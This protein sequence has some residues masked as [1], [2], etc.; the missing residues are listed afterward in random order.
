[1]NYYKTLTLFIIIS[2]FCFLLIPINFITFEKVFIKVSLK[3][4]SNLYDLRIKTFP[5]AENIGTKNKFRINLEYLE[6]LEKILDL[7]LKNLKE[8]LTE[9]KGKYWVIP[10]KNITIS[11]IG[12]KLNK[13]IFKSYV[14]IFN[15][16]AILVLFGMLLLLFFYFK[17][18]YYLQ[19][20]L[21]NTPILSSILIF[22]IAV[23][24]VS[25]FI[26]HH[27][28]LTK[29]FNEKITN[30]VP[31]YEFA[32]YLFLR[33]IILFVE[34]VFL[35]LIAILL[36]IKKLKCDALAFLWL[37]PII[38]ILI[39]IYSLAYNIEIS[40]RAYK[41]IQ[42]KEWENKIKFTLSCYLAAIRQQIHKNPI[43][44]IFIE[45]IKIPVSYQNAT[46]KI[47][48]FGNL[49]ELKAISNE[50]RDF[51]HFIFQIKYDFV[52][53]KILSEKEIYD[54]YPEKNLK[55]SF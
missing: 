15:L 47:N 19:N 27:T 7:D 14:K 32:Q 3:K 48:I 20:D 21:E 50:K 29:I 18:K 55:N 44:K 49:Y 31:I 33:K 17:Q 2:I 34:I 30:Q 52:K 1:M 9:K 10:I 13:E 46:Y 54:F 16:D 5:N 45:N 22:V 26:L 8:K 41:S 42:N 39:N 38:F 43:K 11:A 40:R 24:L 37:V 23:G 6:K 12:N 53:D 28:Q 36:M 4:Y 51:K 35:I 25:F